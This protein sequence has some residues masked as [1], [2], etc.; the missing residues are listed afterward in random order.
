MKVETPPIGEHLRHMTDGRWH[1]GCT[2]CLRR[3][4]NGGTGVPDDEMAAF[5]EEDRQYRRA[6]AAAQEQWLAARGSPARD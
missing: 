6:V 1:D 3:R 2:Y 5:E 4:V